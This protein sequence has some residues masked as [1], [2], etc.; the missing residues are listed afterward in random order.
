[1]LRTR[2]LLLRKEVIHPLLPERIPCY[3]LVPV[4]EFTFPRQR[5]GS[6]APNFIDLTGGVY[7]TRERIHRGLADPRLLPIPRSWGRVAA[8]NPY[9]E[10]I[11]G[12][13]SALLLGNPLSASLY[14]VCRPGH[15][16]HADLT[17]SSLPPKKNLSCPVWTFNIR[18]GLRSLPHWREHP[19][20]RADDSHATP[21]LA[22]SKKS[23]FPKMC[24]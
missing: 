24:S 3:D 10:A 12:I 16:G 20:A 17:S 9:W 23:L 1:M 2:P 4:A 15:K 22:L 21:V 14:Y 6:G 5:R 7:K 19:T 8:L 11:F 13:S 18:Q